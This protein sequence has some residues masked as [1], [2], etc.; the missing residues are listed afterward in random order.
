MNVCLKVEKNMIILKIS[1]TVKDLTLDDVK[2]I[3]DRFYMV[4]KI[5]SR[6]GTG[7]E[8]SIVKGEFEKM[9]GS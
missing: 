3:F 9:N 2:N 7:L 5:R 8:L 4:D 1:N 6:K